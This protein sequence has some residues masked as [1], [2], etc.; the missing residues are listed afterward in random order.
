MS[1][2]IEPIS[3]LEKV[4]AYYGIGGG[5]GGV[6]SSA[7]E[8]LDNKIEA[9]K[10]TQDIKYEGIDVTCENTVKGK[11][12]DMFITGK[13]YQNPDTRRIESV[14]ENENKISII[15]KNNK[16]ADDID[17]KEYKK[18]ILLPIEGGLKSL[19]NEK[20][21]TIEQRN[22]GVYL[23]QRVGKYTFTGNEDIKDSHSSPNNYLIFYDIP[24]I[25][26]SNS[27]LMCDTLIVRKDVDGDKIGATTTNNGI[28]SCGNA[29]EIRI[30]I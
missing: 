13:T 25:K 18:E 3:H 5:S 20:A 2:N 28:M 19:P 23:V 7:L 16:S 26:P 15:S 4:I 29:N 11:V 14:G 8:E 10:P 17:Y 21:D 22:D 6:D 1:E 27:S 12:S 9:L 24:N 30:R